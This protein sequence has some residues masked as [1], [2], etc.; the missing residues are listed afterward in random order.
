ML[1]KKLCRYSFI[2]SVGVVV[3]VFFVA[4]IMFN[5]ENIFGPAQAI[6]G[7]VAFLL[8][9][10]FSALVTGGLILGKPITLYLDGKKKE[11]VWMLFATAGWILL[12]LIIVF[13]I[14]MVV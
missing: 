3:Y 13:G 8:L 7:V 11:A 2:H 12:W 10:V 6:I 5:A 9:F 1:N 14:M 4:G